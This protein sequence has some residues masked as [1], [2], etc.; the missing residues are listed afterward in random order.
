MSN[1]ARYVSAAFAL[2]YPITAFIAAKLHSTPLTL[3]AMAVLTGAVLTSALWRGALGAWLAVPVIAA[4]LWWLSNS[5]ADLLM[6]YIP[7]VLI[8]G[9][10]AWVFGMTLSSSQ[11]P[12][13]AQFVKLIHPPDDP[14]E[15]D[16]WPYARAL[17]L[18]WSVLLGTIA[19]INLVLALLVED[20]LL[21]AA[22][23]T[24]PLVVAQRHWA[25]F[26]NLIGYLLIAGFF[27]CEYVYRR[28]RFPQQP[29]KNF[30]DFLKRTIAASPRVLS[31][32]RTD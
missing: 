5:S 18:A 20:G 15:P 22:G 16:V 4:L 3:V 31:W 26:A 17:T 12:L 24:P 9:F 23:I 13:I 28:R 2:M 27:V 30:F 21:F 32:D 6:L 25:L 7:P 1:L 11:T 14:I 29:Y 8:P 19:L 10:L